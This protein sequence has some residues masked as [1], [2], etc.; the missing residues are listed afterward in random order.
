MIE[1]DDLL[2]K[3]CLSMVEGAKI[4]N[5]DEIADLI[6]KISR[7]MNSLMMENRGLVVDEASKK[8]VG[9]SALILAIY[10]NFEP[11]IN[12]KE[13]RIGCLKDAM[14]DYFKP[15]VKHYIKVRFDVDSDRP[16]DAYDKIV[17][18]FIGKGKKQLGKTFTYSIEDKDDDKITF[19]VSKCCFL[20]FFHRNGTPEMTSIMCMLDTI[21][22]DEFNEGDYNVYF[23]RPDLMS[24]GDD[25]CRFRFHR[26]RKKY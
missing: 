9:L 20:D 17:D 2:Q 25:I 12:D 8:Y 3:L 14:R 7:Y 5:K 13:I 4:R 23:N 16:D 11:A 24:K 18:N 10:H 6:K 21:W 22:A 26:I 1:L 19:T 15:D